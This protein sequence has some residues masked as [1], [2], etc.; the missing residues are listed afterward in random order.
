MEAEWKAG[1]T[2]TL[3][4]RRQA[5]ERILFNQFGVERDIGGHLAVILEVDAALV[6]NAHRLAHPNSERSPVRLAE[7]GVGQHRHAR[8]IAEPA[9][10]AG[11]LLGDVGELL[12]IGMSMHGGVGDQT[13]CARGTGRA[14]RRRHAMAG[15]AHR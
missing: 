12:R 9:G 13:P 1:M 15:F 3:A 7:G 11:G 5:A 14:R 6:E 10:H 4:V 2:R 8:L